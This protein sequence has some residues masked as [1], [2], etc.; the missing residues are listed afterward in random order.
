MT[1]DTTELDRLIE[2]TPQYN[3]LMEFLEEF[4]PGEQISLYQ[5]RTGLTDMRPCSGPRGRLMDLCPNKQDPA[6]DCPK[7]LNT[8][9][10]EIEVDDRD[11]PY[12]GAKQDL[13]YKFLGIDPKKV[14]SQRRAILSSLGGG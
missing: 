13:V 9:V 1:T 12:S 5:F 3:A 10:Y 11:L 7:C 14:E 6:R 2:V 8:G 4:L